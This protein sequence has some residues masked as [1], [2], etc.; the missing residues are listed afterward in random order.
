MASSLRDE[1]VAVVGNDAATLRPDH[2]LDDPHDES[3]RVSHIEPLAVSRPTK[4]EEVA[5]NMS[6][7]R[8]GVSRHESKKRPSDEVRLAAT[9]ATTRA[10]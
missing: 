10:T 2:H 1:L 6:L 8:D 7:Q 3:L 5:A 9:F 4:T